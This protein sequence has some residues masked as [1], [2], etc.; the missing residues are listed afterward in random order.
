M[1]NVKPL[2]AQALQLIFPSCA[3]E[4]DFNEA[5]CFKL[6]THGEFQLIK[7]EETLYFIQ[8]E[9]TAGTRYFVEDDGS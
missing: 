4:A 8:I 5:R 9:T 2:S 6:V 1:N 3:N 7:N